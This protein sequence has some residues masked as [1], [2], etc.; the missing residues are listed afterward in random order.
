[1]AY[2]ERYKY[3]IFISYSHTDNLK[4][5]EEEKGWVE[6]FFKSLECCLFQLIGTRDL[7]IWWDEKRLDGNTLF[8]DSIADA[9]K[10][11]A[12]LVCLNS[13]SYLNS[14][15][16]KK[17][18][19]L[20]YKNVQQKFQGVK[21][22][23]WSRIVNVLLYNIPYQKW[24]HEFGGTTGFP[25][26]NDVEM[27]DGCHPFDI[28][29]AEFREKLRSL[30][31]SLVKLLEYL[32]SGGDSP[33][34][35]VFDIFFGDV[36]DNLRKLRNRTITEVEKQ[37]ISELK[38]HKIEIVPA[39][40]P[41]YEKNEHESTVNGKLEK[42][43]LSV[44]LLDQ[45]PG[46]N[47]E[48]EETVWYP[49]KQAE[50]SLLTSKP[51][52]I[53]VPADLN[54]ETVEEENYRNFLHDLE[55]GNLL[56]TGYK[57]VRSTK[58]ELTQQV[59]DMAKDVYTR[60]SGQQDGKLSVLID[61]HFNDQLY[62]LELSKGLL[63][64]EIQPFINPQEGDPQKNASILE[65]RIRQVSKLIFFYGKISRDWVVERM[66]AAIQLV[67]SKKYPIKEFFVL[68][69]PPHKDPDPLA[70]DQ[71]AVRI[72]VINNSDALQLDPNALQQI[73]NSIKAAP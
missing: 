65:D 58:S 11:S 22:G 61:T 35:P 25:F 73:F 50:L 28:S 57:Y 51:K 41:P 53:W 14:E 55:N 12:I 2:L 17:E 7:S 64:N 68:M 34:P 59:I 63:E 66:K 60:W 27:S 39:V 18:L 42:A 44:H 29:T 23:D 43:E 4:V 47:I 32:K 52:F 67:V 48:G 19:D 16:C 38:K 15:Y 6:Q 5:F 69:L 33:P 37:T 70:L 1:M 46:R 45:V 71:S 9:L 30:C 10:N 49:Q 13:R 3:D 20:F 24:P 62:A 72:N 36:S 21:I 8:D 56:A 40:P 54:I 31:D 26:H